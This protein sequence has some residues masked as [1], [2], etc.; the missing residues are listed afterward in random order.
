MKNSQLEVRLLF[1]SMQEFR[2]VVRSYDALNGYNMKLRYNSRKRA[3]EFADWG[4][5]GGFGLRG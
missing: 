5:L 4:V 1:E 2:S 3:Q